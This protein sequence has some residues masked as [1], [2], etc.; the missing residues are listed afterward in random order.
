MYKSESARWQYRKGEEFHTIN[1]TENDKLN[2]ECANI[3][4]SITNIWKEV[5]YREVVM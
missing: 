1:N 4:Y 2:T 5:R 3:S